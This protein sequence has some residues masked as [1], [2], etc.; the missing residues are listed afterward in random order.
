M[1]TREDILDE[2]KYY[3]EN[4][5]TLEQASKDLGIGKR[6]LQLHLNKLKDLAPETFKLVQDKKIG[7]I[8]AGTI[9]GGETGKRGPTWTEEE[10]IK[11]AKIIIDHGMTYKQAEETFNIPS[12]TIYEMVTKGVKDPE[13]KTKLYAVAEA[14]RHGMNVDEYI[15]ENAPKQSK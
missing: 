6:T 2:A 8:K 11:V 9:K 12:S 14:N 4:D 7:N 3:L 1:A 15:N 13:I 5:V 10:A